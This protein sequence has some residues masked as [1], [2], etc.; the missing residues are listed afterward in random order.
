MSRLSG[1]PSEIHLVFLH[2]EQL[3]DL[4]V[5][6]QKRSTGNHPRHFWVDTQT[7][8]RIIFDN[9]VKVKKLLHSPPS[10]ESLTPG[11]KLPKIN[12]PTFDG[13]MLHWTTFW[14]QFDIA[15]DGRSDNSDTEKLVYLRHSLKDC[16]AKSVIEGLSHSG[17]QYA[18][19][20]ASL[21]SRYNN[22]PRLIHQAHVRKI[23]EVANLKEGS[24]KE[25]RQLHDTVQ[26]HLR[27]LKAMGLEPSGSFI[28]S[29]L[30]LK[31]DKDTMFEWQRASQVSVDIP[32]Y[33]KILDFLDLLAQASETCSTESKRHPRSEFGARTVASH[34]S[35]A[36][37]ATP[38]CPNCKTQ[39]HP[40]YVCP[41]FKALP[42]DKMLDVVR[43][44]SLCLNC[45]GHIVRN[46]VSN[47][48]CRKCQKSH[49]TLLHDE[50][51]NPPA[52]ETSALAVA[53]LVSSNTQ[54]GFT[55]N[56]LLMTCQVLLHSPDGSQV[57]ARGVIDSGS[58]TSFISERLAQ[59]LCLPQLTQSI[60]IPD[61]NLRDCWYS[62][63]LQ[64]LQSSHRK[65]SLQ[66]SAIIVPRVDLPV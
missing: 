25:L 5:G 12:V 11:V 19:A 1:D 27:A 31:L 6:L 53:P 44:N 51:K 13:D 42:H 15:I 36:T 3:S 18:E 55:G 14:E 39:R 47:N 24:G 65:S 50:A 37:N 60:R 20:I 43:T 26:Q 35:S 64:A 21:K 28:T 48:R 54:P 49:H 23:Y 33:S 32:H 66:V 40:L 2:Q 46:C 63:R 58:S 61:Q 59:T 22:R 34:T 8:E 56:A 41:Q 62:S 7:Q 17:D 9:S 38:N 52:K 57:R 29:L 4:T 45:R 10:S 30:E 16:T